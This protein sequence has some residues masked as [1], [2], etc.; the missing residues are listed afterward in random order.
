MVVAWVG[1]A[2]AGSAL[3]A[4]TR[5]SDRACLIAWNSPANQVN[6]LRLLA[7]RPIARLDL[8]TAVIF[9]VTWKK[10]SPPTRTSSQSCVMTV[11]KRREVRMVTGIWK[12]SGVERW[13]FGRALRTNIPI[14]A[15]VRLLADG[16]V[17]KIYLR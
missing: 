3:A 15:N 11:E 6:R 8:R 4:S 12:P 2:L 13:T 16:R 10:G 9:N 14:V 1:L 17:T 7:L 5:P